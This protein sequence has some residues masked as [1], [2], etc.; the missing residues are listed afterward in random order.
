MKVVLEFVEKLGATTKK[1]SNEVLGGALI[2]VSLLIILE[3]L[4]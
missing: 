3:V 4:V 1:L 2:V